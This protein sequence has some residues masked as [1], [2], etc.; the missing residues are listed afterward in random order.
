MQQTREQAKNRLTHVQA[1]LYQISQEE[2]LLE[3]EARAIAGYLNL[4][5]KEDQERAKSE[6]EKQE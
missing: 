1:R 6:Q 4:S 3:D 2:K 5:Q